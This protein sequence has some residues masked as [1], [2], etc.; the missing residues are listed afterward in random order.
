MS[1]SYSFRLA[2][3]SI[4]RDKW[5]NLLAVLTIAAG[6]LF[7]AV[8]M[9]TVYNVNLIIR[10]IPNKFSVNVY[11]KENLQK[12]EIDS[13]TATIKKE[14]S[15]ENI[16]FIPKEDAW[17][18]LKSSL[19][20]TEYILE[21]LN[22]NPLPDTLE[23]KLK[24]DSIN[25]VSVK[26]ISTILKQIKGVSEI[27]YGEKILSSIYS[28]GLGIKTIGLTLIIIMSAGTLFVCYSTVKILFYRKNREIETYKFLGATKWFIRF[29]FLIEGAVIGFSGGFLGLIGIFIL[30]YFVLLK[31]GS[32][33]PIF[34]SFVFPLNMFYLLPVTGFVIG[35][36]GATIAIG[37]IRY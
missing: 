9:L 1:M 4:I 18:E 19:K 25:P 23:I 16:K 31:V 12:Q 13:I 32:T 2:F 5:V 21:G 10:E 7:T 35:I 37:R 20:N 6:L 3:Q 36:I 28:L 11:L 34:S 33:F 30:Y 17:K 29:P 26:K 14:P 8:T 27:E 24:K 22:E 15:V